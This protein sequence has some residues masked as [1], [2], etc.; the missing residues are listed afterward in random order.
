MTLDSNSL[1]RRLI[2]LKS[3]WFDEFKERHA[4]TQKNYSQFAKEIQISKLDEKDAKKREKWE[5]PVMDHHSWSILS[6]T[7]SFHVVIV[8]VEIDS[9][10]E[11]NSNENTT[12]NG[13]SFWEPVNVDWFN[14]IFIAN[15]V[16]RTATASIPSLVRFVSSFG[17]CSP[18]S[19]ISLHVRI[20]YAATEEE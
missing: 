17:F 8:I 2:Q 7:I 13:I 19:I 1:G 6:A 15:V 11:W 12:E 5:V 18:S 14:C 9:Y 20:R 3:I 16:S 4:T 10:M